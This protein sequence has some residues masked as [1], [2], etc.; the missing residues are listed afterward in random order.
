MSASDSAGCSA[1][2]ALARAW[3]AFGAGDRDRHRVERQD[4]AQGELRHGRVA[5]DQRPDALDR[6]EPDVIG[7][8][9]EGFADIERLAVPVE[10]AVIAIRRKPN[11]P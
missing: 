4:P 5:P 10:F 2:R 7:H 11:R 3:A 8:A 6:L 9:G 1:A